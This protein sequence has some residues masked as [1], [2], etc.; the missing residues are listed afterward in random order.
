MICYVQRFSCFYYGDL[1]V[2]VSADKTGNDDVSVI[3][4]GKFQ[5]C[6]SVHD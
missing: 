4:E 2:S 1:L 3:V 6:I 5:S